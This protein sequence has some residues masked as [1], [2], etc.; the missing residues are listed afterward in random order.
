MSERLTS[1]SG[2]VLTTQRGRFERQRRWEFR[3]LG[4]AEAHRQAAL[5]RV[6]QRFRVEIDAQGGDPLRVQSLHESTA[7]TPEAEQDDLRNRFDI[8]RRAFAEW[9]FP[10]E[11]SQLGFEFFVQRLVVKHHVGAATPICARRSSGSCAVTQP[12]TIGPAM[13]P[14]TI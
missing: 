1:A 2:R 9:H 13:M 6:A 14:T 7:V 5:A 8:A 3:V 11:Q 12:K 4:V 10:L